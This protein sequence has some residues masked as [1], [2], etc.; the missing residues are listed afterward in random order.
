MNQLKAAA[1]ICLMM[2]LA[3]HGLCDENDLFSRVR[4]DAVFSSSNGSAGSP[5]RRGDAEKVPELEVK[6]G[7][8]GEL[9]RKLR[10]GGFDVEED[11]DSELVALKVSLAKWS[12]PVRIVLA[13]DQS[14]LMIAMLLSSATSDDQITRSQLLKLLQ[15]NRQYAPASFG[16]SAKRRRIELY[17]L[18]KNRHITGKLLRE[19]IG[20]LA[21]VAV[22]TQSLWQIGAGTSDSS[23]SADDQRAPSTPQSVSLTGKWVATRS[24]SEAFAI[25]LKA[26]GT[27][28]LVYVKDGQQTRSSGKFTLTDGQLT[29]E[30]GKNFRLTGRVS[31]ATS[32]Q[33]ELLPANTAHQN[34]QLIF[35]KAD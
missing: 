15:A 6:I 7:A 10:L 31:N 29:L 35:K 16:Y 20:R 30:G 23:P 4:A 26:D 22:E 34:G 3:T 5:A 2:A 18:L 11:A 25:E 24:A 12:F 19:E 33:F 17:R 14:E 21:Q 8:A 28:M 32:G 9:A 27:F 13:S 1:G